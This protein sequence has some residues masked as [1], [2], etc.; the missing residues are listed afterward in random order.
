MRGGLRRPARL[1]RRLLAAQRRRDRRP[2]GPAAGRA[3]EPLPAHPGRG[4]RRGHRHPGQ[5]RHRLGLRRPLLLG[6]RD[7]RAPVPHVHVP[8]LRPQR[9]ALPLHDARRRPSARAARSTR[10][11]RS[12]RGAR[13]TARR[14]RPTTRPAPRSTTS[15]PT[16]PTPCRSTWRPP[17]TSS[18]WPARRID[19]LVE[20]ARLWAD[21]GFW[22]QRDGQES[23]HIHGV[24]GPDEYT[25]VVNDNLFTNVMARS[26]LR[27]AVGTCAWLAGH[28]PEAYAAV[29]RR[30]SLTTG[31][32]RG[33]ARAPRRRC[34]SRT[35]SCSAS[36]RRT[37]R[38]SSKE[39]W[40][41]PNTP[42]DKRPLLLHYHPLVIYRHQ[43]LKQADV[44]LA[45]FLQGDDFTPEEKRADFE[46]YDPLTTGDSTLSSVVQAIIAAEVGYADLALDYF[47]HALFV[48]L[49]DLHSNTDDGVHVAS[50]GGVWN[51]LVGGFAGMRDYF[52]AISF[53]PRLPAAWECISFPM[54]LRGNRMRVQ[55]DRRTISFT[56]ETGDDESLEVVVQGNAGDRHARGSGDRRS[57]RPCRCC[58]AS[59]RCGTS[60]GS[61]ARTGPW[62]ARPCRRTRWSRSPWR[63]WTDARE[64]TEQNDRSVFTDPPLCSANGTPTDHH[65]VDHGARPQAGGRAPADPPR[66]RRPDH[67]EPRGRTG[68][69]SRRSST[70]SRASSSRWTATCS[71][72]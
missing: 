23:F 72:C 12:S 48:D 8:A 5:G 55:L 40:D 4:P 31:R 30:L 43:V 17:G 62:S 46:Y 52:G 61:S 70:T 71:S 39:L 22:R 25:T 66:Q 29:L 53:D 67:R 36:T 54:T 63:P 24:T 35:T 68:P 27:A 33:V 59:R 32:D 6:H 56:L 58:R 16:S 3:L 7:L 26:N 49:A 64:P 47:T 28:D 20:T 15:T 2:A 45:L 13:S 14:R 44:V 21:L 34:T 10:S 57:R 19:I 50:I 11:A 69:G 42:P 9:A 38:S 51:A 18:S 60:R 1:A 37:T 41:L 65:R